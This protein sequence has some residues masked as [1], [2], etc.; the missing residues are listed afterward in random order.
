M[1]GLL[2][3][4]IS[5]LSLPPPSGPAVLDSPLVGLL[6][7]LKAVFC[8]ERP[9][10]LLTNF[11][12]PS[13]HTTSAAFMLGTLFFVL[14]PLCCATHKEGPADEEGGNMT[15]G[16]SSSAASSQPTTSAIVS[17]LRETLRVSVCGG[18]GG[19]GA[20][21]VAV[22]VHAVVPCIMLPASVP[23]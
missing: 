18:G 20:D 15:A 12:F 8:R 11:S 14:I 13:G 9:S 6:D 1:G 4:L 2:I 5:P 3:S 17:T 22:V 21:P 23:V 10:D 19:G 16:T 7:I